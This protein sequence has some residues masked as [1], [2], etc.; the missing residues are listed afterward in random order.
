LVPPVRG[1]T[2]LSVIGSRPQPSKRMKDL[3]N[4]DVGRAGQ[5]TASVGLETLSDDDCWEHLF[6]HRLGRIAIV[7]AGFPQIFPV[8]YVAGGG[9]IVFRSDPGSKLAHGPGALACFEVDEYNPSSGLGWSVMVTGLLEDITDGD[10]PDSARLLSLS[11]EPLAPGKH[12]HWLALRP[13]KVSGRAFRS[14][15]AIPGAFLG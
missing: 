6:S 9:A 8:N 10:D 13:G 3:A 14:G 4:G 11:V 1:I 15:W 5:R 12:R 7:V 2:A